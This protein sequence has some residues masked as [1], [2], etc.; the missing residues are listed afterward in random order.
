MELFNLIELI[1]RYHMMMN[2]VIHEV[3]V[4]MVQVVLMIHRF[5][6]MVSLNVDHVQLIQV[7][8]YVLVLVRNS[9]VEMEQS[10]HENN[11]TMETLQIMM[12]V[13]RPVKMK[14]VEMELDKKMSSV[15]METIS[16]TMDV[17]LPVSL[18][19]MSVHSAL[20]TVMDEAERMKYS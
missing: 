18:K 8:V 7:M 6:Q 10:I 14:S 11:V 4:M 19:Q 1:Q 5:V 2:S 20:K 9:C 17:L 13:L 12:V 15:T 3:S 16:M